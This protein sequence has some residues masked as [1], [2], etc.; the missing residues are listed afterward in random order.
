[1]SRTKS[2]FLTRSNLRD[3]VLLL[4]FMSS[5]FFGVTTGEV[6]IGFLLLALGCFV[7]FLSKGVLIRNTVLTRRGIYG[8]IRHPYYLA[9]FVID[10]GFCALSGNLYLLLIYPFLFFW[11]YQPTMRQEEA[12]LQSIHGD[13]FIRYRSD[14]PRIFPDHASLEGLRTLF[15]DFSWKRITWKERGRIMRFWSVGFFIVLLHELATKGLDVVTELVH[16]AWHNADTSLLVPLTI[17]LFM[18]GTAATR[19]GHKRNSRA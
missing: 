1:M 3:L 4:S 19:I 11:S 7:H 5:V 12:Y 16:P 14:V 10:Y 15:E 2:N 9:N 8:M 17:V 18:A 6:V 13:A